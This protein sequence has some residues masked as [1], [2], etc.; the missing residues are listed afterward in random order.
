MSFIASSVVS[1]VSTQT[2]IK[3]IFNETISLADTEQSLVL[4]S[5][6]TGYLIK[7]RS[8]ALLKLTHVSGESGTKYLT[9]PK[10]A[11]HCDTNN[12]SGLTLYFQ[13]PTAGAIVEIV[14]WENTP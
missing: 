14:T 8:Q 7:S 4:P 1:N 11:V 2:S 9:I 6:I 10:G 3:K 13:S 12:Y 5:D